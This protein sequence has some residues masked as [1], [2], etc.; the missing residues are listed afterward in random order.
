MD[1]SGDRVAFRISADRIDRGEGWVENLVP[2]AKDLMR[3][4]SGN[5]R[6]KLAAEPTETFSVDL[7]YVRSTI[8]GPHEHLSWVTFDPALAVAGGDSPTRH[9]GQNLRAVQDPRQPQE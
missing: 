8:K 1:R 6:L 4:E 9:R 7:M 3:G 5:V 2:G